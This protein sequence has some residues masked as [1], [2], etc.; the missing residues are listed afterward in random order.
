MR[1]RQQ[2]SLTATS[3]A[4]VV[5]LVLA[6]AIATSRIVQAARSQEETAN[7]LAQAASDL[8]YL[9]TD[10]LVNPTPQRQERWKIRY[11]R[12]SSLV[13]EL[14]GGSPRQAAILDGISANAR[15]LSGV[16]D[17]VSLVAPLQYQKDL[18][19]LSPE[20][21]RLAWSR[22]AV[23]S[24]SLVSDALTL[25]RLS[26]AQ[27]EWLQLL[28]TIV[29]GLVIGL[30]VT[31]FLI[32]YFLLDRRILIAIAALQKG[33]RIVGSGNFDY[34]FKEA[35]ADEAGDLFR[36][37]NEMARQ[38]GQSAEQRQ[39][40]ERRLQEHQ[41]N[42][43]RTITERTEALNQAKL[44]AEE[45]NRLKSSFLA[46]M[47][48]EIRT[49]MNAVIGFANLALKTEL[50]SQQRDYISKIHNA[51]V[52]LLGLI[53]DILD[54]S[55][56]EAGKLDMEKVDFSLQEVI[57]TVSSF[58]SQTAYRKNLE[59]VLSFAPGIP[60]NLVGD[61]HRLSQV[62]LNLVGN[63]VKFTDSGEIEIRSALVQ[64]TGN[65]VELRFSVRDTGIGMDEERLSK[66]FQPFTQADSSTTRRYGGTG[67]GLSISRR[68][69]EMMG[70]QIWAESAPGIGTIFTF[71]AWFEISSQPDDSRRVVPPRLVG[72]RVLV[73]DD[74]HTA[75]EVLR[76]MLTALRFRVD[77]VGTGEEAIRAVREADTTDP[78]GLVLID[79]RMPGIDGITATRMIH[80]DRGIHNFCPIIVMSASGGG[81]DERQA[82][83]EAGASGFLPK[84]LTSS[85]LIDALLRIHAPEMLAEADASAKAVG[86]QRPLA[87]ARILLAEDNEVNQQI[88]RELL[89]GAGAEIVVVSNGAEALEALKRHG[90]RFDLV[91]MDIQMPIM[92]G[93]EAT[94][95]IRAEERFRDL[96]IIAMTAHAMVSERQRASEAGMNDHI[97][98]P[99]DPDAMFATLAHH[100]ST[101]SAGQPTEAQ[102]RPVPVQLADLGA[103]PKGPGIPSIPGIRTEEGLR[104]VAGNQVLYVDLLRRFA[105][106]E[107]ESSTRIAEALATMNAREAERLA[108]TLRGTA[109]NLGIPDVQELAGLLEQSIRNGVSPAE[110]ETAHQRLAKGTRAAVE[111][112]RSALASVSPNRGGPP[113][114]DLGEPSSVLN[115]LRVLVDEHDSDALE[116]ADS[117]SA[118]LEKE[119]SPQKAQELRLSL[120]VYDFENARKLIDERSTDE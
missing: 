37:F 94:R 42:L 41:A 81:P 57:E 99:I 102:V 27:A 117:A 17:E 51:G 90:E 18:G 69:V 112:I 54:F 43:E 12:F 36:S 32:S 60:N 28:E 24:R 61:S 19:M 4:V 68:L 7:K 116:L 2:L 40:A 31:F 85:T 11:Q 9:S 100:F 59:L 38:L 65:M 74:N 16:F 1:V 67:L 49:P 5:A 103:G 45:A 92:D 22:L 120:R 79:W 23:Q 58:A 87:G 93:F 20:F 70:G 111:A 29:A 56:I 91:L 33:A 14:H 119:L 30:F 26:R 72:L 109:G 73:A 107:E 98:K 110:I 80:E 101:A 53:N 118:I 78:Y 35:G 63:A 3:F 89:G 25:S 114:V 46:N 64:Q 8:A 84:P 76:E 97:S 13:R 77:I 82:A 106:T 104:R 6:S 75:Q 52:S 50:T 95:R 48:H 86:M 21:F 105:D 15:R 10:Y 113:A 55:K 34:R 44:E 47:S 96:P 71:T 115:R 39:A 108:H 66:L 83:F 88:A 62:L